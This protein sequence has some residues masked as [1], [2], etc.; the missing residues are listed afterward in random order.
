[1]YYHG[2]IGIL[3]MSY[4]YIVGTLFC[5]NRQKDGLQNFCDFYFHDGLWPYDSLAPTLH[6]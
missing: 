3:C 1:M 5:E 2:E 6:V 4:V